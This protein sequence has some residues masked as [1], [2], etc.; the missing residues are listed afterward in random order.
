MSG[1]MQQ[2]QLTLRFLPKAFIVAPIAFLIVFLGE[3]LQHFYEYQSGMFQSL[4]DFENN[5]KSRARLAFGLIK[6]ASLLI[7]SIWI[8][9][10]LNDKYSTYSSKMFRKLLMRRAWDPRAV[11]LKGI[12]IM[13]I[14]VVPLIFLHFKLNFLAMGHDLTISILILDSLLIASSSAIIGTVMWADIAK[15]HLSDEGLGHVPS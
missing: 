10:A 8:C 13:F 3:G 7:G 2:L 4:A 15:Q 12:A 6:A 9:F 11:D 14:L 5:M 1:F